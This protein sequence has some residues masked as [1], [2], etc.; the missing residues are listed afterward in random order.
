[1]YKRT[2]KAN[3]SR[4]DRLTIADLQTGGCDLTDDQRYEMLREKLRELH[5]K[6]EE[7]PKKHPDKAIIGKQLFILNS[8]ISKLRKKTKCPGISPCFVDA[9]HNLLT[10]EAY[11]V[12]MKEAKYIY[13]LRKNKKQ[14]DA[15]ERRTSM[16]LK[17]AIKTARLNLNP[18]P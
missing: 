13:E 10:P 11:D 1:M 8:E 16:Q 3:Q 5:L 4:A 7:L 15:I 9:A 6:N 17:D 12:I 2:Y 18:T 14:Y